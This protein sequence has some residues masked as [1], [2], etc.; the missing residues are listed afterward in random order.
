MKE[1]TAGDE[2]VAVAD[3]PAFCLDVKSWCECAGHDLVCL[4]NSTEKLRAVIRKKN[5]KMNL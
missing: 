5:K 2:L 1:L 4:E 3:D